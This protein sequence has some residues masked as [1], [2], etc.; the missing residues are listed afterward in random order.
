VHSFTEFLQA[1]GFHPNT[2]LDAYEIVV[3]EMREVWFVGRGTYWESLTYQWAAVAPVRVSAVL[4][5]MDPA[6]A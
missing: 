1:C 2:V 3:D 4:G 6:R 5:Q